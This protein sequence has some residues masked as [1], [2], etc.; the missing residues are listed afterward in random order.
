MSAAVAALV[1]STVACAPVMSHPPPEPTATEITAIMNR[2]VAYQRERLGYQFPPGWGEVRF[3]RFV[4]AA[5]WVSVMSGCVAGLG[6]HGVTF[7]DDLTSSRDG[8]DD[9]YAAV[10]RRAIGACSLRYPL[11]GVRAY[12][13]TD[14]Q[15]D[16]LYAYY[17]NVLAPCLRS[18]GYRVLLPSR[19]DFYSFGSRQFYVW[20]PYEDASLTSIGTADEGWPGDIAS[21]TSNGALLVRKC[22]PKPPGM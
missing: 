13:L 10:Q 1:G 5:D 7:Y 2:Y 9:Q 3:F 17:R 16:Y 4:R 22:P 15:L 14:S 12:A 21:S 6:V 20:N 19:Q 8:G 11:E 18:S